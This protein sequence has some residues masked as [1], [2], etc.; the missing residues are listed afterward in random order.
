MRKGGELK[1][2]V[3]VVKE[4][5]VVKKVIRKNIKTRKTL[6]KKKKPPSRV[7]CAYCNRRTKCKDGICMICKAANEI[8]KSHVKQ[9]VEEPQNVVSD[10]RKLGKKSSIINVQSVVIKPARLSTKRKVSNGP[11]SSAIQN[12]SSF[13]RERRTRSSRT[14]QDN[15][16]NSNDILPA[17]STDFSGVEP[18]S[19]MSDIENFLEQNQDQTEGEEEKFLVSMNEMHSILGENLM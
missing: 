14:L 18:F 13:A 16:N 17:D 4:P 3:G 9:D 5:S 10:T 19:L 8:Y 6:K 7:P 15:G 12:T 2:K 11:S 1:V